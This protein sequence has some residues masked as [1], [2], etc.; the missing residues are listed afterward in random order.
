MKVTR[1]TAIATASSFAPI[2]QGDK[3]PRVVSLQNLLAKAHFSPGAADGIFG[4]KTRAAVIGFQK[5]ANLPGTGVVDGRTWDALRAR[6]APR[7][8]DYT[9]SARAEDKRLAAVQAALTQAKADGKIT[10]AEQ[11]TVLAAAGVAR[12]G[13]EDLLSDQGA[14]ALASLAQLEKFASTGAL[15]VQAD[16]ALSKLMQSR[17]AMMNAAKADAKQHPF[18]NQQGWKAPFSGVRTHDYYDAAKGIHVHLVAIDLLDPKV[19]LQ[20]SPREKAGSGYRGRTVDDFAKRAGAEV[21]INGDFF[22]WG[23]Y[24]PSGL[25]RANGKSWGNADGW[26][27]SLAF[28]GAHAQF[29]PSHGARQGWMDNMVSARPLVLANGRTVTRYGAG[30]YP[31]RMA[32][33]GV[34]L[35]KS[36]RVLYLVAAEGNSGGKGLRAAEMGELLRRQ[37]AWTAM[38][39]DSGGS[40]EMYQKGRGMVLES[41]DKTVGHGSRRAV[42]NA[43]LIQAG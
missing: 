7:P 2:K 28:S 14:P 13:A 33:T 20:A 16:A 42:A 15:E 9:A 12:R 26:E 25:D 6:T 30:M 32:R 43:L 39:M 3:G 38:A 17:T 40:A 4:P 34:G 19:R 18:A 8:I 37:G 31:D 11:K 22:S 1:T 10:S 23:S 24:K 35:S 5:S 36:G 27:P 41:S 21:A 29:V